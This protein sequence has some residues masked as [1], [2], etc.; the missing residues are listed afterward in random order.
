MALNKIGKFEKNNFKI[1]VNVRFV[2][3][4]RIFIARR[5][6][7]NS[8][9]RK[10]ANFLMIVDGTQRSSLCLD[11]WSQWTW[12]TRELITFVSTAWTVF[13]GSGREIS[14]IS[15]VRAMAKSASRCLRRR[16]GGWSFTMDSDNSSYHSWCTRTLR[17]FWRWEVQRQDESVEKCESK[18]VRAR[19]RRS[20]RFTYRRSDRCLEL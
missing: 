12:Q 7:Y 10:Q 19:I 13:E 15:T 16:T 4:K 9:R 1:A 17:V 18:R 14:T 8:K 2:N 11:Y 20:S 3:A 5:S 6:V